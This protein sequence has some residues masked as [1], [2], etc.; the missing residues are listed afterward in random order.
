MQR[1]L[2]A[3]LVATLA[4]WFV[5]APAL[6]A[7]TRTIP[8]ADV[9]VGMTGYGLTVFE[10]TKPD[11]FAV[12]VIGVL[13]NFLP[14]QDIILIRSDDPRLLHSGIVQGMSGSPIYLTGS[15][16][17]R[18]A[19]ALAY[20]W[21]FSKDPIAGVTPIENMLAEL[22]RPLRGR[23]KT[24]AAGAALDRKAPDRLAF[25]PLP[26]PLLEGA[27]SSLVRASVP[28]SVAGFGAAS[29]EELTRALTPFHM[30]PLAAGGGAR[31]DAAT[32]GPDRFEPGGA[33]AVQLVRGD[34][35]ISG[36]GTVTWVDGDRVL[37]FGHP[38]FNV[39]EIYLPV[40]TAEVHTFM[41]SLSSSFKLSSPRREI[42]TL[43]QDRQS[44]VAADTSQRSDMIPIRVKVGVP[45]RADREFN[46]EVVRHR[47]LTPMLAGTV[48]ANAAQEAA[49][50]VSDATITL[51]TSLD[52]RGQKALDLIDHSYSPEGLS[53]KIF[54]S[55]TGIKAIG[56]L[57]FNPFAPVNFDRIDIRVDVDYRPDVA[58]IIGVSMHS[59]EITPGTRPALVVT[60][61]PYNGAEY[62]RSI[63]V[64]I[65]SSLAGQLLKIEAAAGNLVKPDMA[66]P[67]SVRGL[68]DNLRKALPAR[69][70]VVTVETP[71]EDMTLRGSVVSDLPGSVADTLRPGA[72]TRRGEAFKRSARMVVPTAGVTVGRQSLQVRVKEAIR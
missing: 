22:S 39:G 51:R 28:L 49:S 57:L 42:G 1:I 45:G 48:I 61:R 36:V 38:M 25:A 30:T 60:L 72:S 55:S 27:S 43:V 37:A 52:V 21:H 18:L 8:V 5:A 15:D 9:R 14:K 29:L 54:A 69:S 17:D 13:H 16:G 11:R 66:A 41:S 20:G 2:A 70:I 58:E 12:R 23:D 35:S 46:A 3:P 40:A 71:D 31:A 44:C 34:M 32:L 64:E 68:I 6:A 67:E 63:P 53:P 62:T 50:D 65:P 26:P 59:D 56:E 24:P 10:G 4:F 19:G 33:I 7:P 47:F